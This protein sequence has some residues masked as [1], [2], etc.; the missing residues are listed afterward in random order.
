MIH[1]DAVGGV[2]RGGL[3]L[4]ALTR[5][6]CTSLTALPPVAPRDAITV[7]SVMPDH[8]TGRLAPRRRQVENGECVNLGTEIRPHYHGGGWLHRGLAPN[9]RV[10]TPGIYAPKGTWGL[11]LLTF[12]EF[13]GCQDVPDEMIRTVGA[14]ASSTLTNAVLATMVAG[15]LLVAGFRMF[16]GGGLNFEGPRRLKRV[17]CVE[18]KRVKEG[19]KKGKWGL[20]DTVVE[21]VGE[22]E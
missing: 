7:L 5:G 11:R 8:Y 4:G 21:A 10:L 3:W 6:K 20:P 18:K 12:A 14:P 15:K 1:H 19:R 9:T 22:S 13:L 17:P 16:N 2:T